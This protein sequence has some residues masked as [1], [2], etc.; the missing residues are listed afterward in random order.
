MTNAVVGIA[1]V[2]II[3][4]GITTGFVAYFRMLRHR[5]DAQ[6]MAEYR[7]FAARATAEQEE[8]R[9]E[10]AE[11]HGRLKEVESLLRSVG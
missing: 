4:A 7:E 6:A 2:L 10:L 9:R 3:V 8:L 1:I 11:M 5:A